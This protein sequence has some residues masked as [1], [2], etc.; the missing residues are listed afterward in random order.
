MRPEDIA[1]AIRI[2]E[3]DLPPD[4]EA[5]LARCLDEEEGISREVLGA[6]LENVRIAREGGVP[7]CQDTGSLVFFV[8]AKGC[9]DEICRIIK[10][11][12][13]M[14]TEAVPLR[15]NI[16]DPFSRRN[17]GN[18][19][20][21]GN[22]M[23]HLEPSPD[24]MV[25]I[26]IL[27]KGAGSENVSAATMLDPDQS[28]AGIKEFVLQTIRKAGAKPCPPIIAGVG[29]GGSL[30]E[31]ALLSKRALMRRLDEPTEDAFAAH[32][33]VELLRE[34]NSLRIG[35]M[36]FGGKNTALAVR[37]EAADCHT[38]SL[39]VAVSIQCWALRRIFLEAEGDRVAI[40]R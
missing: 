31:A 13:A 2:M 38:A 30:D 22:P 19:L 25:R 3:T 18:N 26:G 4:V 16:V 27:A 14:A 23:I 28:V 1:E 8:G 24:G 39:P 34:I 10:E 9:C 12:V 20:G 32:L 7:M 37:L 35:P 5:A 11:G 21:R 29:V 36:G 6:I 17:T 15:A 33:E 40:R